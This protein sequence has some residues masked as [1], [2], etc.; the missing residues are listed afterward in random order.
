[1]GWEHEAATVWDAQALYCVRRLSFEAVAKATGVA[2]S[3]LKRWS[4]KHG[5]REKRL[6]IAK[7]EAEI[8]A[9]KVIA[10]SKTIK[11]LLETPRADTAFA[12]AALENL[13]L[14]EQEA[15]RLG[16]IRDVESDSPTISIETPADAIIA[17]RRAIEQRLAMLL[18]RPE[19]VNYRAVQE[20]Q[21]C[22]SL[23]GQLEASQPETENG[24]AGLSANLVERI[25]AAMKGEL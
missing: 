22:L 21:K 17:L 20:V 2:C 13:T 7:A 24:E 6:E 11:A 18:S 3:T 9:D 19:N 4:E 1:M 16:K 23:V 25:I 12:V 5:W 8:Q 14:K 15:A 10:R